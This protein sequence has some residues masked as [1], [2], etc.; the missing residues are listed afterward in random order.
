M[1]SGLTLSNKML[2]NRKLIPASLLRTWHMITSFPTVAVEVPIWRYMVTFSRKYSLLYM[3][4]HGTAEYKNSRHPPLQDLPLV[5]SRTPK[6]AEDI[7]VIGDGECS[8]AIEPICNIVWWWLDGVWRRCCWRR[9]HGCIRMQ[10][11]VKYASNGAVYV[12]KLFLLWF[13]LKSVVRQMSDWSW[14]K[15]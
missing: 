14:V 5:I 15:L 2:W 13:Y 12:E 4:I 9:C 6:P 10:P 7:D 11:S 8:T 3:E 1:D